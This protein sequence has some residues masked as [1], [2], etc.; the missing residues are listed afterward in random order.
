MIEPAS[1]IRVVYID[2]SQVLI[3]DMGVTMHR[4]KV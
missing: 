4:S 2:F 3:V 1:L